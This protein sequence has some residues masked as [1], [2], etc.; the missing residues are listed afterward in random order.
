LPQP[1]ACN[2]AIGFGAN[3]TEVGTAV[4]HVPGSANFVINTAGNYL[5]TYSAHIVGAFPGAS[6]T[7]QIA[8][9]PETAATATTGQA[10][11]T[12]TAAYSG[13]HTLAAGENLSL[14]PISS[15]PGEY[16]DA[17]TISIQRV[18]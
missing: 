2:T 14:I 9:K 15:A 8:G 5:I 18:S 13:V 1:L 12:G 16:I 10:G 4:T 3:T 11:S 7:F 17:A 6:A